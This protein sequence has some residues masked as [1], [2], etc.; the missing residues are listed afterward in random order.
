MKSKRK[1]SRLKKIKR[2]LPRLARQ[3]GKTLLDITETDDSV[4]IYV[5]VRRDMVP[6]ELRVS[7]T[8]TIWNRGRST[9]GT[10][11]GKFRGRIR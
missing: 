1:P 11:N 6:Q 2:I 4:H 10:L 9:S 7:V 3:I 5:H 8:H